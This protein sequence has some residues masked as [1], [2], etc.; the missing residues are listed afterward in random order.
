MATVIKSKMGGTCELCGEKYAAGTRIAKDD[1][2]GKWVMAD[3]LFPGKVRKPTSTNA[4]QGTPAMPPS[5]RERLP[6][7]S[8]PA[9]P[10]E[11]SEDVNKATEARLVDAKLML[12]R[13]SQDLPITLKGG[14]MILW[15][16]IAHQLWASTTTE[17]I[18]RAKERNITAVRG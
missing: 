5:S 16:E 12:E 17:R 9:A 6:L 3:C 1:A 15:A 11:S 14:Y 18:Q 7:S 2:T 10:E 13:V 4:P 8:F